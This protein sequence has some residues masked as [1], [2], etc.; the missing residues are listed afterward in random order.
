MDPAPKRATGAKALSSVWT[1]VPKTSSFPS[2]NALVGAI[3]KKLR[4]K[5]GQ[6]YATVVNSSS[7]KKKIVSMMNALQGTPG[8]LHFVDAIVDAKLAQRFGGEG[9]NKN[10]AV[11]SKKHPDAVDFQLGEQMDGAANELRG[12]V[13]KKDD[14]DVWRPTSELTIGQEWRVSDVRI[15]DLIELAT[16]HK[17][18]LAESASRK[19]KTTST[20]NGRVA[21][22]MVDYFAAVITAY[23][24]QFPNGH[25]STVSR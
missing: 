14:G 3:R 25:A 1:T 12:C 6:L 21:T 15:F 18:P 4:P 24:K 7:G 22:F 10:T 16:K 2:A 20:S 5:F 8:D 11:K 13:V 23:Y 17:G 19:M 9:R